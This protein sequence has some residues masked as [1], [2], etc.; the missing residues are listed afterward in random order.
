MSEL[1]QACASDL[2]LSTY[3]LGSSATTTDFTLNL[4]GQFSSSNERGGTPFAPPPIQY[5]TPTSD[6]M[7]DLL[8]SDY[9]LNTLLYH[10]HRFVVNLN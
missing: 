6:R 3:Y 7:F 2:V 9:P 1:F 4:L 8:I 10:L 5:P